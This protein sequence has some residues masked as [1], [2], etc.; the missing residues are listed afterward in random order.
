MDGGLHKIK[1]DK[2]ARDAVQTA[3]VL[4]GLES[5][6]LYKLQVNEDDFTKK[7]REKTVL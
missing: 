4:K 1:P 2:E 3:E 5:P 7:K 6:Q